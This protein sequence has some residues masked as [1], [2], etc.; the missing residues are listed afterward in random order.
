MPKSS[1]GTSNSCSPYK[2]NTALLVIMIFSEGAELN[3]LLMKGAIAGICSTLSNTSS[4]ALL[5][6]KALSMSSCEEI[7]C[8]P[9]SSPPMG[10]VRWSACRIVEGIRVASRIVVRG[11]KNT[12]SAKLWRAMR[13]TSNARRVLPTPPIPNNVKRRTVSCCKRSTSICTCC[14]RPRSEVDGAGRKEREEV[15]GGVGA[16]V[17]REDAEARRFSGAVS[18]S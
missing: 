17:L 3:R 11:T 12:P 10:I 8:L 9:G 5:Y 15:T 13:A 1:G 18:H 6:K 14:S 4:N 2:C 16:G 7:F